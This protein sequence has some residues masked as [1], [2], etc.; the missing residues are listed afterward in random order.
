MRKV[1][2]LFMPIM[3]AACTFDPTAF[4][5][6]PSST[7][8]HMA[9]DVARGESI[10]RHGTGEA[11]PCLTCHALTNSAFGLGPKMV[12]IHERAG[13]RVEGLS[14][15]AYLQQSIREPSA[16]VV[17]GYRDIMYPQ[18]AEKLSEQDMADLLAFLMTL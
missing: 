4:L 2:L 10:F 16:F 15:E 17:P 18:Y 13:S 7:Q 3:L 11:P 1:L 14:A 12:G 8:T 6:V 9:G 5:P